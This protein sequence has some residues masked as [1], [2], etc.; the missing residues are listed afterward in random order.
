MLSKIAWIFA[1][2]WGYTIV[3]L[4][5]FVVMLRFIS[6]ESYG[7]YSVAAIMIIL[8]EQIGLDSFESSVIRETDSRIYYWSAIVSSITISG[9]I[10]I[11]SAIVMLMVYFLS[12]E[13]IIA[14]VMGLM[15]PI[16]FIIA[17]TSVSKAFLLKNHH[18]KICAI[19][20]TVSCI[21]GCV[22]GG[23][24]AY[25]GYEYYALV[26]YHYATS[27]SLLILVLMALYK[28]IEIEDFS[29][30]SVKGAKT[31]FNFQVVST[32]YTFLN[33]VSNRFD[34]LYI[35]FLS[36]PVA[37]G[38]FGFAKRLI[39]LAQEI[40]S[41]SIEKAILIFRKDSKNKVKLYNATV[42][43]QSLIIFVTMLSFA[44]LA[45]LIIPMLFGQQWNEAVILIIV[46]SVGG[47]FR[48]LASI[49]RAILVSK[50]RASDVLSGRY[51]DLLSGILVFSILY[52]FDVLDAISIALVFTLRQILSYFNIKI[53]AFKFRDRILVN[54]NRCF[55][56]MVIPFFVSFFI[57]LISLITIFYFSSLTSTLN[58]ILLSIFSQLLGL[59]ICILVLKN[60]IK[61]YI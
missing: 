9:F 8:F 23:V 14:S 30:F 53:I 4:L 48:T 36:T 15:I 7:Y 37:A 50:N 3:S 47:I 20:Q 61:K 11:T 10:A 40:T 52:Y 19:N 46:M 26:I 56:I 55:S 39:Q 38:L 31:Y 49:D 60:H 22:A 44:S 13:K 29:S 21:F 27:I 24:A 57:C 6:V 35:G 2:K 5:G 58:V 12:E 45:Q 16:I 54:I 18:T 28:K 59:C 33:I 34:V 42:F 51:F 43:F 41:S 25:D 32:Y 1:G 17:L